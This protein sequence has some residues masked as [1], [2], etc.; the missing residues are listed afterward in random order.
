MHPGGRQFIPSLIATLVGAAAVAGFAGAA[1]SVGPPAQRP[2]WNGVWVIADSFMDKQDGTEVAAPGRFDPAEQASQAANTPAYKGKYLAEYRASQQAIAEGKPI[3]DRGAMCLPQGMP[4]FWEG[5]YAFEII[6]TRAQINIY[7]EWNEQTRRIY[8]NERK[9]PADFDPTYNGHSIGHWNGNVLVADTV[10]IRAD[11]HIT[12]DAGGHH[13]DAIHITERFTSEGPERLKVVM[14]VE[15]PKAF[16]RP[17]VEVIHLHRKHGMEVM[18]YVCEENN[19]NPVSP[20]GVTG[21]V[22]GK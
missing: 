15:D 19:R 6:Q 22:L 7:Q 2:D 5:P 9:Q 18:E 21:T 4:A 16:S 12:G 13:S 17:W 10:G 1:T 8:L 20:S 14:S 11:T 3:D